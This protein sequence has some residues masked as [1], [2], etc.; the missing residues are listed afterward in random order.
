MFQLDGI[1]HKWANPPFD[2]FESLGVF[3]SSHHKLYLIKKPNA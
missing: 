1:V 3:E 2:D